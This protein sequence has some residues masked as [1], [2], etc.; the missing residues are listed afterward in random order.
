MKLQ[1]LY[2]CGTLMDIVYITSEQNN[3]YLN[4][5]KAVH[6]TDLKVITGFLVAYKKWMLTSFLFIF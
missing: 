4:A 5:A 6:F 1:A 2:Q 3:T